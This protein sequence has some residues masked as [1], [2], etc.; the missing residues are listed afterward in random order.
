MRLC[1]R[2]RRKKWEKSIVHGKNCNN[3]G[4]NLIN[5]QSESNQN[6]IRIQSESSQTEVGLQLDSLDS[7]R[8]VGECKVLCQS[9]TPHG[10]FS[11]D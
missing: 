10:A 6:P 5:V 11:S 1:S 3:S 9:G 2:N 7:I 8:L 4:V